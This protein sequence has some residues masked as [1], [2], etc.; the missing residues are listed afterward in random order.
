MRAV[1]TATAVIN[2]LTS[3]SLTRLATAA[4]AAVPNAGDVSAVPVR[5]ATDFFRPRRTATAPG[6]SPYVL[7]AGLP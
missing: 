5:G 4:T 3:R 1:P 2:V 7:C 6:P